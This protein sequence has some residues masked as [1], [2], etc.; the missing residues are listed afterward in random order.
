MYNNLTAYVVH[1]A[2]RLVKRG[3]KDVKA[4]GIF[5]ETYRIMKYVAIRKRCSTKEYVNLVLEAID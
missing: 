2:I 1:V 3:G 5:E 4:V